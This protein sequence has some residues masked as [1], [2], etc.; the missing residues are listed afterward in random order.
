MM[1]LWDSPNEYRKSHRN[2]LEYYNALEEY[3]VR[4]NLVLFSEMIYHLEDEQ[5]NTYL[6]TIEPLMTQKP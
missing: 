1:I 5:L 6:K 4:N 2:K 3:A